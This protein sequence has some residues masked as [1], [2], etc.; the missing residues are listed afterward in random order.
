MSE[1]TITGSEGLDLLGK[2]DTPAGQARAVAIVVHGFKGYMDYG[3][4]PSIAQ[5]LAGEGV[6][7]HRFNLAHS[8]MTR[9]T[10]TFEKPELFARDTWRFQVEDVMAVVRAIRAQELLGG[11]LPLALIGHSR[12]GAT[13][14]LT[15]GRFADEL[16]ELAGIV[17]INAPDTCCSLSKE[18][19][20]KMLSDG[21]I[22]SPSARTGQALRINASWLRD[23]L[24]CPDEHDL[25]A[26]AGRIR[27]SALVIHGD[28]DQTVD[29]RAATNITHALARTDG[30]VMIPGGDH[31]LNTPNPWPPGR[32]PPPQLGEA[33]DQLA[34]F[35]RKPPPLGDRYKP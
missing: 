2:T 20:A 7:A 9:N 19:R 18:Q 34:S 33:L 5:R 3:M 21:F 10:E 4:F 30:P 14:L 23:Q 29:P 12:G 32:K 28:S 27:A 22:E 24:D 6:I 17:T 31:V 1:W 13:C 15:A 8:G 35:L 26:L 25:L 11:G 16:P